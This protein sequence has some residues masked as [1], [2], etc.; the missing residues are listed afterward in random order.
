MSWEPAIDGICSYCKAENVAFVKEINGIQVGVCS[1]C[2]SVAEDI[3]LNKQ[4]YGKEV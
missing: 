4:L 3:L 1:K 2:I